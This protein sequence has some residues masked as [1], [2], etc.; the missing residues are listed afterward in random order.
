[1]GLTGERA[2]LEVGEDRD[3][4]P[5][6]RRRDVDGPDGVAQ[7][8][9]RHQ[10]DV[11]VDVDAG[12]LDLDV[13]PDGHDLAHGGLRAR[14]RDDGR[15]DRRLPEI[16]PGRNDASLDLDREPISGRAGRAGRS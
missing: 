10:L 3:G 11:L 15:V 9:D 4:H 12:R 14:H 7:A 1:M 2:G 8:V 16:E 5:G 6:R 13:R